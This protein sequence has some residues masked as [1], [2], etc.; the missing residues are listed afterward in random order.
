MVNFVEITS[1]KT[2]AFGWVQDAGNLS[3]LCNV[4]AIFDETSTFHKEIVSNKIPLLVKDENIKSE[5]ISVLNSRPIA[6]TY[7][8]LTGSHIKPRANSPCD[9]IVQAAVKGQKREYI[10]DWPADN[11]VRWAQAF[12]FISYNYRDD[13]FSV[14]EFG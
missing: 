13:T 1:K 6:I 11:F 9:G 10:G 7:K 2:R 14:T 3:A 4:V 8:L 5:M 12:G